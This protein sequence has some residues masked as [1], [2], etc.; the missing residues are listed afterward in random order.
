[1]AQSE[2]DK[3]VDWYIECARPQ[4][5]QDAEFDCIRNL[6]RGL[7]YMHFGSSLQNETPPD[8]DA[9]VDRIREKHATEFYRSGQPRLIIGAKTPAEPYELEPL[10]E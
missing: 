6:Q 7:R 5:I 1:M 3:L 2:F 10:Q 4:A 8:W 9:A